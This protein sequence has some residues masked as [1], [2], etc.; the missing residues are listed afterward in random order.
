MDG[1]DAEGC[2]QRDQERHGDG[3][4]R[5]GLHEHADQQEGNIQDQQHDVLVICQAG[6]RVGK[7]ICH[8]HHGN[9]PGEGCRAADDIED[10]GAVGY[11]L[12]QIVI[13]LLQGDI[14]IYDD[15]K[16]EGIHNRYTGRFCRAE[17][18]GPDTAD[19][20]NGGQQ[21]KQGFLGRDQSLSGVEWLDRIISL[22]RNEEDEDTGDQSQQQTGHKAAYEKLAYR[23]FCHHAVY[24]HG[25]GRRD[26]RSDR[27]GFRC[28]SG[29]EIRIKSFFDHGVDFD[30]AK[31]AGVR[32]RGA[33]HAGENDRSDNIGVAK[34]A[35]DPADPGGTG[36]EQ[37][38][39][40][41]AGVHQLGGQNKEGDSQQCIGTRVADHSVNDRGSFELTGH[42]GRDQ[43]SDGKRKADRHTADHQGQEQTHQ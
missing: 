28:N 25:D 38:A 19:D 24:D 40:N 33:A 27:S 29:R 11:G 1:V 35:G 7:R 34:T 43:S 2:H 17:D 16:D 32:Y 23:Y 12:T 8:T 15:R 31:A 14:V 13:H 26:D 5:Q 36:S 41:T 30:L 22:F 21:G 42:H 39:G 10:T 18:T 20:N 9:E 37:P 3:H 6:Q 4:D